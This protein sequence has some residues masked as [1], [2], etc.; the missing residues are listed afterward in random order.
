MS[1]LDTAL[2]AVEVL[3]QATPVIID[4]IRSLLAPIREQRAPTPEE[5]QA[6]RAALD[7]AEQDVLG[8]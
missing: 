5:W 7:Q 8:A 2:T 6:A 3:A 4:D 1:Y